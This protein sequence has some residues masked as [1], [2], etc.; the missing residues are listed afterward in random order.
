MPATSRSRRPIPNYDVTG[1]GEYRIQPATALPIIRDPI[2]LDGSTQPGGGGTPKIQIDG[3]T[4]FAAVNG[5]TLRAGGS[6]IRGLV[7]SNFWSNGIE[8]DSLGTNEIYGNFIGTDVTGLAAAA[9]WGDGIRVRTDGNQIG[10]STAG[11]P[12]LI[13]GNWGAG[14]ALTGSGATDNRIYN[15]YIGTDRTGMAALGNGSRG[16]S[17]TTQA[18]SNAIG[19][20]G[21]NGNVISGNTGHGIS[22]QSSGS[23]SNVVQGNRIGIDATGTARSRTRVT[24]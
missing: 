4:I 7:I 8:I 1:N 21:G 15:N 9:N 14:I 2:V 12:N 10:S 13:S 11:D 3:G 23:S 16:V 22:I 6:T 17:I 19:G 18:A 5:L 24:A 20:P